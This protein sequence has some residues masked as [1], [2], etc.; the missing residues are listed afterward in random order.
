M[1]IGFSNNPERRYR[2]HKSSSFNL[3]SKDYNEAN[4]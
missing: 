3:K 2:D 1:Y 4:P